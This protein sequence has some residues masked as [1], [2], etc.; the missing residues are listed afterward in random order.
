ME[1]D[2]DYLEYVGQSSLALLAISAAYFL[3]PSN[4]ISYGTLLLI[5]VL[6]GYTA[7]ISRDSFR[8]ASILSCV[9][10]IFTPLG[11][12]MGFIAVFIPLSNI[13]VS[14]FS[15]GTGFKN[16]SNA[17]LLPMIFTGLI[18]GSLVF[19]AAQT[20]PE[21][22][23]QIVNTVEDVSERQTKVI[24][25]QTQLMDIQEDASRQVVE[26]TSKT[27]IVLTRNYV[28]NETDL[29]PQ[30]REAVGQ[31]MMDAQDEIPQR[32]SDRVANNT[33]SLDISDKA[34]Q[35]S[36]NFIEANLGIL[37]LLASLTFYALNPAISILTA[38][39]AKA[40]EK[41]NEKL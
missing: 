16:Y 4:P 15:S 29:D 31:A 38:T 20:Q 24:M 35:A 11:V 34:A 5:P 39:S 23:Q 2:E 19:G 36:S 6:F 14:L 33:Q 10:L 1:I 12:M 40:F 26:G 30:D 18:L 9:T 13:L 17:T 21:V 25:E 37:I 22:R 7:Y 41:L 32:L 27:T 3:N 28:L 8:P